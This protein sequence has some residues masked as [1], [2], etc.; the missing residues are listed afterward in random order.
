M[1]CSLGVCQCQGI[2][3][4][5][6]NF[7][8]T[9]EG[10]LAA[11]PVST[12]TAEQGSPLAPLGRKVVDSLRTFPACGV[13]GEGAWAQLLAEVAA[14]NAKIPPHPVDRMMNPRREI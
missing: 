3:Q 7:S 14:A 4:P 5:G 6:A 11:S 2:V 9:I 8:T 1:M 13:S 12:P 10:P